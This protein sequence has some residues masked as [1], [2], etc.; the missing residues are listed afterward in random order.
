MS[1]ET[2]LAELL[3]QSPPFDS[4]SPADRAGAVAA[5]RIEEEKQRT[6]NKNER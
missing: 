5:A 2:E 6:P 4:L 1:T 3:A